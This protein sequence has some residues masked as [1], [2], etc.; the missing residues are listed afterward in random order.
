SFS[1]FQCGKTSE[2]FL[3]LQKNLCGSANNLRA[4]AK[5]PRRPGSKC[6]VRIGQGA[7]HLL[8]AMLRKVLE[9]FSRCR[10]DAAVWQSLAPSCFEPI[11]QNCP[12]QTNV[13]ESC[14]VSDL[15]HEL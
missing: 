9:H 4:L 13:H 7:P 3:L 10:I 15:P 8:I 11:A 5:R 1:H 6:F 14:H 12:L 2:L